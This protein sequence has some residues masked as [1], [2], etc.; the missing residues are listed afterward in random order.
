MSTNTT[1]Q[2]WFDVDGRKFGGRLLTIAEQTQSQVEVERL[3]N[4][5]FAHWIRSDITAEQTAAFTAQ[6]AVLLNKGIVVW[7][8]DLL[9]TDLLE[10]DDLD[11]L[12]AL[13][14]GFGKEAERFRE[15]RR[16]P[17]ASQGMVPGESTP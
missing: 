7:P 11:F 2:F 17:R 10:S 15:G 16:G 5:N 13:W 12:A 4:G 3:T 14:E 9:K 6:V 1:P 8:S